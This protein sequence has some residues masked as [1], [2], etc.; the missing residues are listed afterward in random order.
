M[1]SFVWNRDFDEA[2][3]NPYNYE[4][5]KQFVREAKTVL[6]RV[7]KGLQRYDFH[8]TKNDESVEKAVWMLHNDAIDALMDAFDLLEQ[9]KH[10]LV[11]RIFRDV[12]ESA[13][14][15]EYFLSSTPESKKHLKEW[16]KN[17][18]INHRD[19][20]NALERAGKKEQKE[21][22]KKQH[23]SFSQWTHRSYRT[24]LKA[25]SLGD[26]EK[27]VYEGYDNDSVLPHTV[28]AYYSI[29]GMLI[30][31]NVHAIGESQIIQKKEIRKIMKESMEKETI[32]KRFASVL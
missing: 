4:A 1:P 11:G 14:L 16:F 30:L 18:I 29:L 27:M 25:Y 9:K 12:W 31:D 32:K 17:E 21:R 3:S 13:Q 10:R 5:Q 7:Q 6:H 22:V 15:V 26:S 20:R 8:F 24:L 19:I 23:V 28:S 2:Y